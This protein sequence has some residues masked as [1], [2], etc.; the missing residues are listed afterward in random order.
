MR[1]AIRFGGTVTPGGRPV[2][3]CF[4]HLTPESAETLSHLAIRRCGNVGRSRG[5]VVLHSGPFDFRLDQPSAS[6]SENSR[7]H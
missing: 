3:L 7:H 4:I 2:R 5:D 6:K 1:N